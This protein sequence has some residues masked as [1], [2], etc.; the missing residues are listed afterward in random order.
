LG[1][2]FGSWLL[3]RRS[4]ELVLVG[5]Y[6]I[7]NAGVRA[8][9]PSVRDE[10]RSQYACQRQSSGDQDNEEASSSNLPQVVEQREATII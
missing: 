8:T 2:A 5:K 6:D 9:D 7:S 10:I 4:G 3:S 1:M